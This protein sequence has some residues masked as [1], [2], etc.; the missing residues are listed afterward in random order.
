LDPDDRYITA[1][2]RTGRQPAI[3]AHGIVVSPNPFATLTGIDV[4]RPGGNAVDAALAVSAALMAS[5]P[6]Q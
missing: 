5:V 1:G 3:G 6:H 2:L 4:L